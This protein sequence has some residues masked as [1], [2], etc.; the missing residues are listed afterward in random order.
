ML[1]IYKP[2]AALPCD[3]YS[4]SLPWNT[5]LVC[6]SC[7]QWYAKVRPDTNKEKMDC[8]HTSQKCCVDKEMLRWIRHD[9]TGSMSWHY[10]D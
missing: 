2:A 4:G 8:F 7:L 1:Y 9:A 5:W 6:G 10:L 3:G